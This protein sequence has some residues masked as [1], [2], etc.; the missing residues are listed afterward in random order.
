MPTIKLTYN[1]INEMV[2]RAFRAVLNESI[3]EVQG[4]IMAKNEYVIQEIVDY[5]KGAWENIKRV[6]EFP[7]E[8]GGFQYDDGKVRFVG[9]RKDYIVLLPDEITRELGISDNFDINV[10]IYDH[11][12]PQDKVKYFNFLARG[13]EGASYAGEEYTKFIKTKNKVAKA[14][15]DFFTTAING[16]LQ[17]QGFYSTL[18]HEL[19]HAGSALAL[20]TKHKYLPDDELNKLN[21]FSATRRGEDNCAHYMN[22]N[23]M[24][25]ADD[26]AFNFLNRLA[27]EDEKKA[28]EGIRNL[29]MFFYSLWETTERNARAEAIYGDLKS[30]NANRENFQELYPQ[31]TVY[32]QIEE[33]KEELAKL[34][35]IPTQI[36][37]YGAK[38]WSYAGKVMNMRTRGKN[39]KPTIKAY[40][41]YLDA[42]K[43][44]FVSRSHKLIDDLYRKAMKVAELYL[45]RHEP[46]KAPSR[47]QQYKNAKKSQEEWGKAQNLLRAIF[48]QEAES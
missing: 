2:R 14:R 10:A 46:Q 5:V 17:E 22:A 15:V 42:V 13:T 37:G 6:G 29:S 27:S 26:P 32:Q 7:V 41:R 48:G 28:H 18:Y 33:M 19:N 47:L 35:E 4:S 20:Q 9:D 40:E 21:F 43:E 8:E 24:R 12:V 36:T 30:L 38:V 44:R 31:T 39:S 45:Q 11:I 34:E 1:D 23:V 3:K 16:E 25:M